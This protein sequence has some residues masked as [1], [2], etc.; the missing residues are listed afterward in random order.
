ML[1][2]QHCRLHASRRPQPEGVAAPIIQFQRIP[3][4]LDG[5]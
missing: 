3:E 1:L 2:D 4:R 5:K